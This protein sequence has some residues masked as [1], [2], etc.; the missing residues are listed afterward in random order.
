MADDFFSQSNL[1]HTVKMEGTDIERAFAGQVPSFH[2]PTMRGK[3]FK[4]EANTVRGYYQ[5][6]RPFSA[7]QD[8]LARTVTFY[9]TVA[10]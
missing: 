7:T 3:G 1:N 10:Q 2:V 9:Q 5:L 4:F 8:K 6:H